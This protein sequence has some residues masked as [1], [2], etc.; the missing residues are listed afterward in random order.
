MVKYG[1]LAAS[2]DVTGTAGISYDATAMDIGTNLNFGNLALLLITTLVKVTA[3][4]HH[5]T[6]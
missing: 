3:L 2:Y 5:L 1:Y 6:V 4:V